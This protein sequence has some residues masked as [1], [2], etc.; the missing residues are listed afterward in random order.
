MAEKPAVVHSGTVQRVIKSPF[1]R[2]PEKAE[3]A[4]KDAD[5]LYREIRVENTLNTPDGKPVSLKEGAEVDVIIEADPK[6]TKPKL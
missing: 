3:I 4:L 2:E 5:H 6:D 1:P